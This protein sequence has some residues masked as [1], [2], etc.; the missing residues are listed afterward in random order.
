MFLFTWPI[1]LILH[2]CGTRIKIPGVR[3]ST[4]IASLQDDVQKFE[5]MPDLQWNF[6]LIA[7]NVGPH[8]GVL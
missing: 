1:V 4:D 7:R 5:A 2:A 8:N 6:M 3:F